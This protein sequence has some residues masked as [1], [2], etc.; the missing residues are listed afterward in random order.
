MQEDKGIA[1]SPSAVLARLH[2]AMN[3]HDLETM[4]TC[5]DPEYASEFPAHPDRTFRGNEQM[6]KNWTQ[7][8][9]AVPNLE[10]L[11]LRT[12]V[13]GDTVWA[14]WEWKGTRRDG[15]PHL[16]R[17][18]TVQGVRQGRIA[19]VRLYMEPVQQGSGTDAALRATL[20]AAG[21]QET[22]SAR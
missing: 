8:F 5:F 9:A 21:R 16:M 14:E 19:W 6:R 17:G 13:D 2:R 18:V 10:A 15:A 4:A 20:G 1:A 3:E 7:I 22:A 12:V 11:L